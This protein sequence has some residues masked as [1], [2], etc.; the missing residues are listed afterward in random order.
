MSK[1]CNS[2]TLNSTS[3]YYCCDG[4]N[5]KCEGSGS[6]LEECKMEKDADCAKC[7]V[8]CNSDKSAGFYCNT[9]TG[10]IGMKECAE[11]SCT[12]DGNSVTC[13][14]QV[15]NREECNASST[16]ACKGACSADKKTG[17]YWSKELKTQDC[18]N[19]DCSV[20]A[21]GYVSCG[22]I[23][24]CDP[25][26]YQTTCNEDKKGG[27]RCNDKGE[28]RTFTCNTGSCV[29]SHDGSCQKCNNGGAGTYDQEKYPG[30]YYECL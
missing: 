21:S 1:T 5:S 22:E 14:K 16:A 6:D 29:V 30:G 15:D 7:Q 9:Q 12:I 28:V 20:S 23:E 17:Y 19:A 25:A 2:C 26:T 8:V 3:T 11:N 4:D 10:K 18:P 24:T 27:L 13:G